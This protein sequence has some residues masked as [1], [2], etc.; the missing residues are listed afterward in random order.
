MRTH[1]YESLVGKRRDRSN[2]FDRNKAGRNL[3]YCI[4]FLFLLECE[5]ERMRSLGGWGERE[6]GPSV[7][8]PAAVA[9][10]PCL[11]ER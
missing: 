11:R 8:R 5:G 2:S 9:K 1:R 7:E 6:D 10:V 3:I 4:L